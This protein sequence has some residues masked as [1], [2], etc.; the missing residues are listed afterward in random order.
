M[1]Q[2]YLF[3]GPDG[4]GKRAAALVFAQSLLCEQKDRKGGVACGK[5]LQCT[6]AQRGLHP[7]IHVYLPFPN[8]VRVEDVSERIRLLFEN[9]YRL[10]DFKRRPSLDDVG[11][12]SSKQVI[13]QADRIREIMHDLRFVPVEGAYNVGIIVDADRMMP[14]AANPFLKMLEEPPD[15]TVLILTAE[16]TDTM[17]P[18]ILSRCQHIRFDP[19]P[20][21]DIEQALIE[22]EQVESD[23]ASFLARMANGSFT[24]SLELLDNEDLVARRELAL[25]YIRQSF[26][27]HPDRVLPLIERIS[28]MGREPVKQLMVLMLSWVRDLVLYQAAGDAAL[29]V[30][31]DQT[32][33]IKRFVSGLPNANPDAMASLIEEGTRLI[34]RN[35][36]AGLTLTVLA[37]ALADAMRGHDRSRL[38]EPLDSPTALVT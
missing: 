3:R 18:T 4:T 17:L 16:R 31:I 15:R 22:R 9:P 7:D 24:T 28:K 33:A 37:D 19:L 6:K 34:E 14:A 32:E 11:K 5:C 20:V 12:T 8:D 35:S 10:V 36:H 27:K 26:S 25:E 23:R 21:A 1:A 38:F 29:L 2:S 13:Y 30:N